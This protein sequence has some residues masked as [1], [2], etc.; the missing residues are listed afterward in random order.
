MRQPLI[1]YGLTAL[2]FLVFDIVWLSTMVSSFYRPRMESLLLERPNMPVAAAFYLIYVIGMVVFAVLPAVRA[3]DWTH[4][5]WSGALLGFVAYAT[6]DM[7]NLATML[8]FPSDV[9]LVDIVW[10]TAVTAV[11]A[12]LAAVATSRLAG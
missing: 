1:A 8:G 2:I 10:G 11:S 12:T 3:N 5:A 7:T 4:A 6:Y 9:A